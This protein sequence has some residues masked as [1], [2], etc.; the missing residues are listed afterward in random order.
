MSKIKGVVAAGH[1]ATAQAGKQILEAGGNAID[2]AIA[3]AFA[4]CVADPLLTGLGA[5][6]YMLVYDAKSN[7]QDLFDF[8]VVVPGEGAKKPDE[9][10]MT[11]VTVDFGSA[12][13]IF[14]GGYGSIGVPGFVSGLCAAHKK[15]GSMPLSELIKPAQEIAKKGVEVTEQQDYLIQ[16]LYHLTLK[17]YLQK[18]ARGY[19]KATRFIILT[20]WTL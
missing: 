7:T 6:G 10:K 8:A 2:A 16:I 9:I 17:N 15:Y 18:T 19:E 14:H 12:S 3:S 5:G 11:P 13:Q 1:K 20:S 4:G